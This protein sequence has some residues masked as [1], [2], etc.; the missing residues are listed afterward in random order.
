MKCIPKSWI[1]DGES[2]CAGKPPI[3]EKHC[4][5]VHTPCNDKLGKLKWHDYLESMNSDTFSR[6]NPWV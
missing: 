3:D 6:Q 2:D 1:C 4:P 5:T